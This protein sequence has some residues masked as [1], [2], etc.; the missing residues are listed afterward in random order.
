MS[1]THLAGVYFV[2][3]LSLSLRVENKK[4]RENKSCFLILSN[5]NLVH[6]LYCLH[7]K[8]QD[9]PVFYPLPSK[10]LKSI[11]LKPHLLMGFGRQR[12]MV[13]EEP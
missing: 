7:F 9:L 11:N 5:I 1:P 13:E 8:A 12:Q 6:F 10:Y 4:P 2:Y 3:H